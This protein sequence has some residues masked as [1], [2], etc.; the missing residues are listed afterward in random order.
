MYIQTFKCK[1]YNLYS[2]EFSKY[3]K[4]K[5]FPNTTLNSSNNTNVYHTSECTEKRTGSSI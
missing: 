4:F 3:N 2:K 5:F 1:Y